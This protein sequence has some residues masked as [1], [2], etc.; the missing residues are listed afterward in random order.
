MMLCPLEGTVIFSKCPVTTCMWYRGTGSCGHGT[1]APALDP[2]EIGEDQYSE[3]AA[4]K[5]QKTRTSILHYVTV[6]EFL[7]ATS[8]KE[9]INLTNSDFPKKGV[10][11][12]WCKDKSVKGHEGIPYEAIVEHVKKEL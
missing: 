8:G 9:L 2:D 11:V 4:E 6:G 1:T 12:K 7:E 10:F 5:V 3:E